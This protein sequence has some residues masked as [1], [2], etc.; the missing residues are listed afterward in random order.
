MRAILPFALYNDKH[1]ALRCEKEILL[2]T[3]RR[4]VDQCH[5]YY[6]NSYTILEALLQTIIHFIRDVLLKEN[7]TK[8]STV[9]N[10]FFALSTWSARNHYYLS[11]RVRN[12]VHSL[13]LHL[14]NYFHTKFLMKTSNTPKCHI[15]N[16]VFCD[17][18]KIIIHLHILNT[19]LPWQWIF[20]SV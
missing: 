11:F 6:R 1:Y 14:E 4:P 20:I 7:N 8:I 12:L 19:N 5:T 10:Y 17:L 9:G 18:T 3:H 13:G 2:K 16:W 15:S